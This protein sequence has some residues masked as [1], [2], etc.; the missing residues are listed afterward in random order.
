V[1]T[2]CMGRAPSHHFGLAM[3]ENLEVLFVLLFLLS[4]CF[5]ILIKYSRA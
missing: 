1:V 5:M 3:F 2:E 4:L